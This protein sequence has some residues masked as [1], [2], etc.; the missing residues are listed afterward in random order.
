M[1]SESLNQPLS[2]AA[3]N[4]EFEPMKKTRQ[5]VL[6][7]GEILPI[8]ACIIVG[9]AMALLPAI[10]Q[11]FKLGYMIW[12]GNGDELFMLALGSQAYFNH[13]AYLSDPVLVSGGV[14]LFRQLPLLPGVWMAWVLGLGPLGIDVCWRILAGLSLAAS[15]YFLI[16]HFVPKPWIAAALAIVLMSDVGLLSSGLFFRQVQ[17]LA[18]ILAGSTNPFVG[19]FVHVEWRVATP[20]LTMAYLLLNLWL[21]TRARRTP[22]WRSLVLSGVSFGLLFHVYPYFWTTAA[23]ALVLAFLIDQGH[24]RVYLWIGLIGGLIG[25]YRIFC[26]MML[27]RATPPDWLIRSDKFVH[28]DRFTDM[29]LPIVASLVLIVGFIWIWRHHRELIYLWTMGFSGLVLFKHHI[30]T[31]LNIEN[32]HWLYLWGPCCSLLLLLMLV[33]LLPRHGPKARLALAA[34]MVVCLADA[35]I[36]LGLR[37]A[38]SLQAEAGLVLVKSCCEYQ[39]QRIDVGCAEIRPQLHSCRRTPVHQLRVNP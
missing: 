20:A 27:K 5:A 4:P 16:R 34:L 1:T 39:G 7:R 37:V 14:S 10:I 6:S 36:G 28:V 3:L 33:A 18:S 31:G 35:F 9:L 21:V 38:E 8:T 24:R 17:L 13:P 15:W 30:L 32:Y 23:A 19:D 12:I 26:D 29:K 11:W 25:S 22:T 2:Q